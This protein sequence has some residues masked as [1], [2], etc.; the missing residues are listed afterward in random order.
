MEYYGIHY[1]SVIE[2]HGIKGQKW[3]VRNGPPYPLKR[4]DYDRLL[5]IDNTNKNDIWRNRDKDMFIDKS[6]G[7]SRIVSDKNDPLDHKRKYVYMTDTDRDYYRDAISGKYE[8]NYKINKPLKIAGSRTALKTMSEL[9]KDSELSA[10]S[11]QSTY[12][13]ILGNDFI[14]RYKTSKI[15]E[16]SALAS[17]KEVDDLI[18]IYA[19]SVANDDLSKISLGVMKFTDT[20]QRYFDKL[21]KMGYDAVI[22]IEDSLY[23]SD[24]PI[25]VLDPQRSLAVQNIQ[26]KY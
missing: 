9:N 3:G 5:K 8:I 2:H 7:L 13:K 19:S 24:Y 23:V 1:D 12:Y 14:H 10:D 16:L 22:D 20:N 25:I 11:I 6:V 17:N 21:S 18:G 26:P 4:D 15:N